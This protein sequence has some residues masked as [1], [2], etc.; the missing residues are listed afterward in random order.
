M[1]STPISLR[2]KQVYVDIP[3]S[4]YSIRESGLNSGSISRAASSST[5]VY[6]SH[7]LKEN[8]PLRLSHASMSQLNTGSAGHK[9]K[10]SELE[11][12]GTPSMAVVVTKKP[13]LLAASGSPLK[14]KVVSG[15]GGPNVAQEFPN[16]VV[17]CHQC[18]RKHD[19]AGMF[20]YAMLII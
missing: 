12:P 3:P 6:S 5:Q 14:D 16:G 11:P 10:L 19:A 8:A 18:S 9:R 20:I 4:P 2:F 13:K 1:C 7:N 17:Y 15:S